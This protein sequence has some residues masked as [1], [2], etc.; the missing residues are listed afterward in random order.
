MDKI[1]GKWEKYLQRPSRHLLNLLLQ[2]LQGPEV[3]EGGPRVLHLLTRQG[4]GV[5]KF[6]HQTNLVKSNL[7]Y[8]NL[9]SLYINDKITKINLHFSSTIKYNHII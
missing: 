6:R 4:G 7:N 2:V 8:S 3:V 5:I 1:L 9:K